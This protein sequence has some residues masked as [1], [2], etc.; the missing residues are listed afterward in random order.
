M[1]RACIHEKLSVH[2]SSK[3]SLGK[4]TLHCQFNNL[5]RFLC[6]HLFESGFLHSAYKFGMTIVNLL[7]QLLIVVLLIL[8][9][10]APK[11]RTK[12]RSETNVLMLIDTSAGM[13]HKEGGKTRLERAIEEAEGM[14][15]D[16]GATS[17]TIITA[18]GTTDIRISNSKD[19]DKVK[20]ALDLISCT[21][22]E[23]NINS[24]FDI[25]RTMQEGSGDEPLHVVIFTDG[26]GAGAG[27]KPGCAAVYR[28]SPHAGNGASRPVRR[29]YRK[30]PARRHRAGLF[31]GGLPSDR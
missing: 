21:D 10:M 1:I 26:S 14:V 20:K 24:A 23:G 8:S 6:K 28:L 16:S 22:E 4:H 27:A 17:F 3:G 7:L 11:I 30:R 12:S 25:V 31:A 29:G 2:G 5:F 15:D 9:L 19:K 13:Q 18:G